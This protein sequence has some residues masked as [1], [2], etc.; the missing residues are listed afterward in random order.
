MHKRES[1]DRLIRIPLR[2]HDGRVTFFYEGPMPGIA[3][4]AL[5]D[6][7][8][9]Q[10]HMTN[11]VEVERLTEHVTL[12]FLSKGESLLAEVSLKSIPSQLAGAVRREK[13]AFPTPQ[14]GLVE[15]VLEEALGI[16][17]RGTRHATLSVVHC[18]IP[19]LQAK[20]ESINQAC[21]LISEKF[22]PHRRSHSTNVF[23]TT[24]CRLDGRWVLLDEL[25]QA[26]EAE[27]E[28][29]LIASWSDRGGKSAVALFE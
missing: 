8:V 19:A 25:R 20:A 4:G 1:S 23:E 13:T 15:I 21:R 5:C 26:R 14:G 29:M 11:A 27:G 28:R 17:L 6:L 18:V 9:P 2:Y 22:E 10:H 7:V 3:E 24:Y 16:E 12:E